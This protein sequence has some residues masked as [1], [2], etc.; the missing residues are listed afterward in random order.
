MRSIESNSH[1]H[2]RAYEVDPVV[3][4]RVIVFPALFYQDLST[5]QGQDPL[6]RYHQ[7]HSRV[8]QYDP[9]LWDTVLLLIP[10]NLGDHWILF[11]VTNM[12]QA[13]PKTSAAP[14]LQ[15]LNEGDLKPDSAP[16]SILALNPQS[17]KTKRSLRDK[18]KSYLEWH[19]LNVKGEE[20]EFVD[21]H[22]AKVAV[23]P[24]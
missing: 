1:A 20:L 17:E 14:R 11:A 19:Y 18:I 21:S 7:A 6:V 15:T 3:C 23:P 12:S 9:E 2:A 16:F 24:F 8:A 22:N 13:R 5:P 10:A 4:S